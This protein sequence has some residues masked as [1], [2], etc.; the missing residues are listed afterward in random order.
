M[1]VSDVQ[2]GLSLTVTTVVKHP[3]NLF[4]LNAG[5]RWWKHVKTEVLIVLML[6]PSF[7]PAHFSAAC[8][9]ARR[10]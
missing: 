2:Q 10:I 7:L 5:S 1:M 6:V 4:V 3:P 9:Q 8:P